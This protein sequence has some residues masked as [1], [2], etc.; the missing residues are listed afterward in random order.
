MVYRTRMT[1]N[2][3]FDS[4]D[5]PVWTPAERA[6]LLFVRTGG[7]LL[8][9]IKK[10]G[11]G[12]GKINAPGGRIE[13]GETAEQAA[14]RE[15]REELGV[16]PWLPSRRG[17][18]RFQF[19]DGFSIQAEVFM[20]A[21]CDGEPVETDEA[22]PFWVAETDLPYERMWADDRLWIPPMLEGRLFDGRFLFDGDIMLGHAV[23]L[24]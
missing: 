16:T 6:T 14:V 12:A 17:R 13:P 3:R 21:G 8:L 1:K 2:Q 18:L 15:V 10:R 4:I 22:V 20:S 19:A 23:D 9:I 24:T 11:L 5:W 7:R